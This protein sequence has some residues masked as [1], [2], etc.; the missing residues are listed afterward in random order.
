M[1]D[2]FLETSTNYCTVGITSILYVKLAGGDL[3]VYL[4]LHCPFKIAHVVE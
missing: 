1:S 4:G 2:N 3:N